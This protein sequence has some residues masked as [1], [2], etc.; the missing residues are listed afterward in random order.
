MYVRTKDTLA[1]LASNN[2][3][4]PA[5]AKTWANNKL[6]PY[7]TLLSVWRLSGKI[8]FTINSAVSQRRF[9][10][11]DI[12]NYHQIRFRE[13]TCSTICILYTSCGFK[14]CHSDNSIKLI[15]FN[16]LHRPS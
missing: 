14:Q 6:V 9:N 4:S 10:S 8:Q 15:R 11:P 7:R 12:N 3:F 2:N 5:V 1:E 13:A 16:S